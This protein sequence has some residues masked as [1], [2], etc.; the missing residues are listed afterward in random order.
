MK[1]SVVYST[2]P[3]ALR[4]ASSRSVMTEL[5]GPDGSSS[6]LAVP[7]IFSYC[8]TVPN[9]VPPKVADC[10]GQYVGDCDRA[11]LMVI[12]VTRASTS[13][14]AKNVPAAK[15]SAMLLGRCNFRQTLSNATCVQ[16]ENLFAFM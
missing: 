10:P 15:A 6:P 11:Q 12:L 7:R 3:A 9:D 1:I 4:G 2:L 16:S 13:G 5:R 8:P 14:E